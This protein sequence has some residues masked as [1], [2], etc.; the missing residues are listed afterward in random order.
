MK[1]NKVLPIIAVS[2]FALAGCASK[3][4]YNKFHEEALNVKEA[5][6]KSATVKVDST[7]SVVGIQT[8]VKGTI[9]FVFG[10][11]WGV[12][13]EDQTLDNA[14]AITIASAAILLTAAT[15]T[16]DENATYYVGGGFKVSYKDGSERKFNEYGLQTSYKAE[17]TNISLSYSK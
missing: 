11:S 7:S 9:H 10:D 13:E 16:E 15:V 6:F 4:D 14:A 2:A 3:V 12:K 8:E 17:G 5:P 1:L